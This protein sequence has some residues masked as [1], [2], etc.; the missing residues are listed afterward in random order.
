MSRT[1]RLDRYTER[2]TL[3]DGKAGDW[4]WSTPS[5]WINM[6]ATRAQRQATHSGS[7][8][9]KAGLIHRPASL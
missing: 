6:H 3:R 1:R 8:L 5:W 9:P 4:N 2:K 7:C